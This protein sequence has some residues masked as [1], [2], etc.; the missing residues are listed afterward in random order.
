MSQPPM[1][2]MS[3]WVMGG[4]AEDA[5]R[6]SGEPSIPDDLLRCTERPGRV[7][8]RCGAPHRRGPRANPPYTAQIDVCVP[9]V[10][11]TRRCHF[12]NSLRWHGNSRLPRRQQD[13]NG[14][15]VNL[16]NCRRLS[17]HICPVQTGREKRD[18]NHSGLRRSGADGPR[19]HPKTCGEKLSR[20]R[21]RSRR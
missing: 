7:E 4:G 3:L 5:I 8:S 2:P 17:D 11:R 15:W 9:G 10:S 1:T 13:I 12:D 19:F 6:S 14:L 20:R 16:A 21:L 18:C